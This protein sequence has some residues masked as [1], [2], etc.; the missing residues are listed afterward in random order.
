M[1]NRGRKLVKYNKN[2]FTLIELMIVVTIIGIFAAIA[3]PSYLQYMQRTHRAEVQAEM[4]NIAQKL[5]SRKLVNHSY[6]NSDTT[7]NTIEA[8]YG[9]ANSPQQ[10]TALYTLALTTF[11]ASTWVITATPISTS[12]QSG[13]GIICLND[14]GQKYWAKAATVCALSA[15]STWDGR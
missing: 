3:Y 12:P 2:G 4:I 7:K 10:G 13:N 15:T 9:S 5:E 1:W 6:L 11:T 14:Q 8:I